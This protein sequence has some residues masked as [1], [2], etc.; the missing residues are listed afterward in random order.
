M[1]RQQNKDLQGEVTKQGPPVVAEIQC[2]VKEQEPRERS[3]NKNLRTE[4]KNKDLLREVTEQC[5]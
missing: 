2:E 5:F 4:V 1:E 3:Q